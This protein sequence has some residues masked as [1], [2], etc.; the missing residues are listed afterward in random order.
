MSVSRAATTDA[1]VRGAVRRLEALRRA[2]IV[3]RVDADHWLIPEDFEARAA[4][5]EAARGRQTQNARPLRLRPRSA[6]DQ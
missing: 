6:G 5:Y 3:E 1:Y 4:A 2:G